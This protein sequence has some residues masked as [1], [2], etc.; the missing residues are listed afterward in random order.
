MQLR[1]SLW[2]RQLV[3]R[4][5]A[6]QQPHFSLGCINWYPP[7]LLLFVVPPPQAPLPPFYL[8]NFYRGFI[9]IFSYIHTNV[10]GSNSTPFDRLFRLL[11]GHRWLTP[12][13]L[14][15]QEAE[16]RRIKVWSQP[17]QIVHKTISNN[18][19]QRKAGKV[20][21]GVGPE[22]EPQYCKKSAT[23]R[24]IQLLPSILTSRSV[25]IQFY[26]LQTESD[27]GIC[28]CR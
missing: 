9:K 19:S 27:L 24:F 22:F 25:R 11:A 4:F 5:K 7:P 23:P 16:I 15:T 20:A 17:K 12:V 10:L 6:T 1:Y 2:R 18:P 14:A 8:Q 28:F 13:I 26:Y 21:E 3:S